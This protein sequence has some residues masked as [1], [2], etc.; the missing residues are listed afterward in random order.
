MGHPGA[1]KRAVINGYEYRLVEMI[2][3]ASGDGCIAICLGPDEQHY[4]VTESEW[5]TGVQLLVQEFESRGVV[6]S[7]SSTSAKIALFRSLFKGREDVYAKSYFS[8]KLA[9]IGYAPACAHEWD[10][11]LCKKPKI[12]CESCLH[13]ELLPLDDRVLI[14]HFR[15]EQQDGCG[16]VG[17]YPVVEESK[18]YIL[19]ADFDKADWQQEV[20]SFRMAC[21]QENLC[22]AVERSRSGNGAHAW[23]FFE[24]K[25]EA[26]LARDLGCT[27]ITIAMQQ[28][29]AMNFTAYDRLF[30][31]QD[32]VQ[33]NGLGNLIAL[34]LQ[35]RALDKGNS[36]FVDEA[37]Q[38][39]EDQWR[40]LSSVSRI[41]EADAKR[42]IAK[43]NGDSLGQLVD[44]KAV[45]GFSGQ[46]THRLLE[47]QGGLSS[48]DFPEQVALTRANMIFIAKVGLSDAALNR[49]RRLAAFAN[50]E[51]YRAQ[52]MRQS[53]YG[54]PRIIYL[55]VEYENHIALPRG[56]EQALFDFLDCHNASYTVDDQRNRGRTLSIEFSGKLRT[57][58]EQAAHALFRNDIGVLSAPTG[59]GKTVIAA[60]L[61]AKH[62]VRTLILVPSSALLDQ[63]RHSLE[64]FLDIDETLPELLTK[65]GRKSKKKRSLIGQMGAGKCIPSGVIDIALFQALF[66]KGD[67]RGEKKVK[68]IV[69]EYDLVICDECHHVPAVGFESIMRSIKARY[70]YGFSATPKRKDGLDSI[71]FMHCGPL[72]HIVSA[73]EQATRQSFSRYLVPCFSNARLEHTEAGISFNQILGQLCTHE[74][75]NDAI[76]EDICSVLDEGRTP[77]VLTRLRSHATYLA[78]SLIAKGYRI[79]LLTGAGTPKERREKLQ[80]VEAIPKGDSFAIVATGNYIGEG[81]DEERLDTL[82]LAAPISWEGMLA[83]YV[84]RLH[85]EHEGKDSVLVYDYIDVNIPMLDRMYKKRL[86]GYASLGYKIRSGDGHDD[87]FETIFNPTTFL[88]ALENDIF[89]STYSIVISASR[90]HI[91]CIEKLANCIGEAIKRGVSITVILQMSDDVSEQK[92]DAVIAPVADLQALGCAII[93]SIGPCPDFAVIDEKVVWYGGI[94][95]LAFNRGE[96]YSLR[97]KSL[98]VAHDLIGEELVCE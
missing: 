12:R 17:L 51:F 41:T 18:T 5:Q 11:S 45:T 56:C 61:I 94:S 44:I 23:L 37:F 19:V 86:K 21:E 62:K 3:H 64:R 69:K 77:L 68:D 93:I 73:K 72:R 1:W 4:F 34:P 92:S 75:R 79:I 89:T 43:A 46:I 59:F 55:G 54:K 66:E 71:I 63:W 14:H 30:P 65:T 8:K 78:D 82:F 80:L 20:T 32:S 81:F 42:I 10:R 87:S 27:L 91:R 60:N 58:Q 2:D 74:L 39:F 16:I 98:E 35:G 90:V 47:K 85:R 50:P 95:L 22:V 48:S 76:V 40:F 13:R 49:I 9:R 83:Q 31:T 24:A 88:V 38:P 96:E 7:D 28:S 25:V 36:L 70:V 26:S 15:G 29:G 84:G 97:F 67:V 52:A 33:E 53:V 57:E 6:T